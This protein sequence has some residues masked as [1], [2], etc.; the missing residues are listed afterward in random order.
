[1][2]N[3]NPVKWL[4]LIFCSIRGKTAEAFFYCND[5][6]YF[7]IALSREKK[8]IWKHLKVPFWV[9]WYHHL[10]VQFLRKN[11]NCIYISGIVFHSCIWKVPEHCFSLR[12]QLY[13]HSCYIILRIHRCKFAWDRNIGTKISFLKWKH[14][15]R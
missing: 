13:N 6:F 7:T 11:K 9:G 1:M 3:S 14:Q 8:N 15:I 5:Y 4:S 10:N 2:S 12:D